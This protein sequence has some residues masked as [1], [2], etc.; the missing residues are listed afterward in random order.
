MKKLIGVLLLFTLVTPTFAVALDASRDIWVRESDGDPYEAD[1]IMVGNVTEGTRAGVIDFDLSGIQGTTITEVHLNICTF[2][3]GNTWTTANTV[4]Q[5][6]SVLDTA[7]TN[8][9]EYVG[10]AAIPLESLGAYNL[11]SLD[12]NPELRDV[13]ILSTGTAADIALVQAGADA[14][15]TLTLGMA[16]IDPPGSNGVHG[17]YWKDYDWLGAPPQ[18]YVNEIPEPMTLS[19]LGL[20]GLALLRR[21]RN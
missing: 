12:D 1:G 16:S 11:G 7:A 14:G 6:S 17:W 21:K 19:L 2:Y 10:A 3:E 5:V 8:Y 13:Y 20:G 15:G 4:N 9:A 18:L